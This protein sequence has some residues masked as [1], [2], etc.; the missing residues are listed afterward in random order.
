MDGIVSDPKTNVLIV[1]FTSEYVESDQVQLIKEFIG[2]KSE[3]GLMVVR[4]Q[5]L[6]DFD[7][8]LDPGKEIS[9]R[10]YT[11]SHMNRTGNDYYGFEGENNDW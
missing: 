10:S 1:C 5:A 3:G 4:Y 8:Q 2:T 9:A 11:I 7:R 6:Q